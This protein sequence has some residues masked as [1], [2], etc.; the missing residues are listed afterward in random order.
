MYNVI[1]SR[2]MSLTFQQNALMNRGLLQMAID[3]S[4]AIPLFV[5]GGSILPTQYPANNTK[6]RQ[7]LKKECELVSTT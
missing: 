7:V 4:T 5:R 6:F 3:Q 2:V 1:H